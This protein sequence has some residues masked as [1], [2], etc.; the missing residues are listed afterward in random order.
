MNSDHTDNG[1]DPIELTSPVSFHDGDTYDVIIVGARV[2]GA[3]TAMLLA[4][5]GMRVLLLERNGAGADTLSTHAILRGGVLQL[6]RWGLLDEII[7]AG[8]P[9]MRR[10]TFRYHD[11]RAV[12]DIKQ[13]HGVDALYA[14]R[15][16]LLD[17]LLVRAAATRAPR[18]T[19]TRRCSIWRGAMAPSPV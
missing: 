17:P 3:A 9:P 12:L 1:F 4:R 16:T 5:A 15:R 8:T 2:A 13:S 19:T 7:D 18:C 6:A 11:G 10:V 14:P